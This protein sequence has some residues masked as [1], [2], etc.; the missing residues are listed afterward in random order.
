[1]WCR[2]GLSGE[3]GL[4]RD[5]LCVSGSGRQSWE[6]NVWKALKPGRGPSGDARGKRVFKLIKTTLF[7]GVARRSAHH[8]LRSSQW[9]TTRAQPTATGDAA[10]N[11]S[12]PTGSAEVGGASGATCGPRFPATL[13]C[14]HAPCAPRARLLSGLLLP[15]WAYPQ[16]AGMGAVPCRL[17]VPH[18]CGFLW[19]EAA[20]GR[21]T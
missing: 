12:P 13:P 8:R 7:G 17:G 20:R 10:K 11:P 15:T 3:H 4:V 5:V 6:G 21:A 16:R 18:A 14:G 19:E 2:E 9:L 1:M